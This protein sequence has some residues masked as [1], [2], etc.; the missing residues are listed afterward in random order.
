M[1]RLAA[2]VGLA[3]S[4]ICAPAH[5]QTRYACG[6]GTVLAVRLVTRTVATGSVEPRTEEAESVLS[7]EILSGA[8]QKDY[9]L[10]TVQ[11][12]DIVYTG[13]A[14]AGASW[15]FDP[16]VLKEHESI[17]VCANST[18]MVL[19]RLDGTDFRARIAR[20]ERR[21]HGVPSV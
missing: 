17:V 13:Q 20:I 9:Y 12:N 6:Q 16:T 3:V 18:Q 1:K 5:A 14:A 19:D 7:V 2:L 4:L 15:N 8:Q 21:P 10:V 11:V